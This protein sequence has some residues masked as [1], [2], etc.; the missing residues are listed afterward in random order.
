MTQTI[1]FDQS[2]LEHQDTRHIDMIHFDPEPDPALDSTPHHEVSPPHK[3][4]K[5][6]HA[7]GTRHT[8]GRGGQRD[9]AAKAV[10]KT[11]VDEQLDEMKRFYAGLSDFLVRVVMFCVCFDLIITLMTYSLDAGV[12]LIRRQPRPLRSPWNGLG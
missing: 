11:G 10:I 1:D 12:K 2:I 7:D 6:D 5:W 9:G 4:S 3:K 8:M